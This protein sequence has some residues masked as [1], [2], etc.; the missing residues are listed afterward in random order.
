MGGQAGTGRSQCNPLR[1]PTQKQQAGFRF[2]VSM[3]GYKPD[4]PQTEQKLLS[5]DKKAHLFKK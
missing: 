4:S 1:S 3:N 2:G 5:A